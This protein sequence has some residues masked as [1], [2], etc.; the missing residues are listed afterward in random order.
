MITLITNG[1]FWASYASIQS[2]FKLFFRIFLY[3]KMLRIIVKLPNNDYDEMY[4]VMQNFSF[5]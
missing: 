3:I 2:E 5:I 4:F 1:P